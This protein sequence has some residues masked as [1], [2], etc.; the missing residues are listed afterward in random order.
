ME[1]PQPEPNAARA[2]QAFRV[3]RPAGIDGGGIWAALVAQTH[4]SPLATAAPDRPTAKNLL[5]L[6]NFDM[7]LAVSHDDKVTETPVPVRKCAESEY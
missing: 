6:C 5:L 4:R 3:L 1:T 2:K 7:K